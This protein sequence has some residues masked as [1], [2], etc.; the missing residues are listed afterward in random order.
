MRGTDAQHAVLMAVIFGLPVAGGIGWMWAGDW[1][2]LVTGLA[3]GVVVL[4]GGG[5]YLGATPPR[6]RR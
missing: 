4:V 3:L 1:R 6:G 2:W 5:V